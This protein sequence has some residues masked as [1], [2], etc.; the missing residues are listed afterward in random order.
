MPLKWIEPPH[1]SLNPSSAQCYRNPYALYTQLHKIE[2]PAYWEDYSMWCLFTFDKINEIL[3]SPAFT[4]LPSN[5]KQPSYPAHLSQFSALERFSLLALEA[6]EHTRL[7][8]SLNLS[9]IHI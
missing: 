4:R 3:K 5:K 8:R 7:R 2:G 9:L 1:F 6:P